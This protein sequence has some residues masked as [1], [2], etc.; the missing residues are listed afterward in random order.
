MRNFIWSEKME[1][2][3]ACLNILKFSGLHF[4]KINLSTLMAFMSKP[5]LLKLSLDNDIPQIVG[6]NGKTLVDYAL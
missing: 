2:K 5:H 3:L 4:M 6:L 1:E